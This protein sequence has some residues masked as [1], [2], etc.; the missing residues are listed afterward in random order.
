MHM[1]HDTCVWLDML[2][3][4]LSALLLKRESGSGEKCSPLSWPS[5]SLFF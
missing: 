3:V 5:S 1:K 4:S 2:S